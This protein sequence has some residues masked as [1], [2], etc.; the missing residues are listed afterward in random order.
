MSLCVGLRN[1]IQAA[2]TPAV[3]K[4][5][6]R[7][8]LD[9]V[10]N[11]M[12]YSLFSCHSASNEMRKIAICG[13]SLRITNTEK[14]T[15]GSDAQCERYVRMGY[16][17]S[18]VWIKGTS[19]DVYSSPTDHC[20]DARD[21]AHDDRVEDT[22]LRETSISSSYLNRLRS[23]IGTRLFTDVRVPKQEAR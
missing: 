15:Q 16:N 4:V 20:Y 18:G 12:P 21:T 6:N 22:V 10:G 9:G 5:R 8:L 1:C 11:K 14:Y 2:P 13:D 19:F 7:G 3:E 23:T 17:S